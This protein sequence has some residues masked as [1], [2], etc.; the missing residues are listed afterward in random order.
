MIFPKPADFSKLHRYRVLTKAEETTWN[1]L[2]EP[3]YQS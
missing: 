2:F 3:I 1:K